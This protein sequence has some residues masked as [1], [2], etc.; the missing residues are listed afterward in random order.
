VKIRAIRVICV[1]FFSSLPI[2]CQ[3]WYQPPVTEESQPPRPIQRLRLTFSKDGPARYI[4]HL[5]LARALERALNR[6]A[7][8]VAYTQGFNR[9]PRLSLAAALPL[10]YTSVAEVADV[11]LTEAVAP[12]VFGERLMARMAPGIVV[13]AVAEVPP[14]APSLQQQ[15]AES[16]YEVSFPDGVAGD[17]LRRSVAELL[18]AES[19]PRERRRPKDTRPQTYD[20]RPL[21]LDVA[22]EADEAGAP[23]LR[24][25][26]VQ[27]ATQ[28][29]R[30]DDVLAA[31]GF[32]PLATRVRRVALRF[33]D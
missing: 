27:S 22:V 33:A 30:P 21:L 31:L 16:V 3:T 20:L 18:A 12:E 24:L 25:R 29:A 13:S 9:R 5:D 10:G 19:L 17:E 26:L 1:P 6:A 7:L 28:T 14:A 23:R 32:D 2:T 4:S 11:W 8:P 15:M